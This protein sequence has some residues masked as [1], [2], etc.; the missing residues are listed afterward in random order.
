MNKPVITI[1]IPCI[2]SI[3]IK[4]SIRSLLLQ[5]IEILQKCE[6]ILILNF[7]NKKKINF[8]LLFKDFTQ[9]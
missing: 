9:E 4:N 5:D 8:T 1:I 6:L 3:F 2:R 7:Q